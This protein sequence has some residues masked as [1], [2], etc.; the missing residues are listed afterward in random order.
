MA[1]RQGK[2]EG[3]ERRKELLVH[4]CGAKGGLTLENN[5]PQVVSQIGSVLVSN[6]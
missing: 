6:P 4:L 5:I 2:V 3:G 1:G